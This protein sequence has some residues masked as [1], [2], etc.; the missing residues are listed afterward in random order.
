MINRHK[1]SDFLIIDREGNIIYAD[2]GNPHYFEAGLA[3]LKGKSLKKFYPEIDDSYP[4][5]AAAREGRSCD[6]FQVRLT[7]SRGTSIEKTGC[8][9]PI[10]RKG[11]PVGAV[12][13]S[14]FFYDREHISEITGHAGHIIYRKN[15]TKYILEDIITGDDRMKEIKRRIEKYGISDS[16]VLIYGETGTGKELVAQSLHNCSR[17]YSRQFYSLNCSAIPQNLV[18]SL[19]FGTTKGS[20]TGAEDTKGLF[21]QADGGTLFLDEIN[22]LDIYSQVKIFRAVEKKVIRR[23]GSDQEI[24]VDVRIIAATNEE[25]HKLME[26]GRLKPDLYYRLAGIYLTLPRLADRRGDILLLSDYFV[27]Y[28]NEKMNYHVEYLSEEIKDLFMGYSWPGNVRELRNI[29]EGAF[30]F[31]E[32]G[33]IT[34]EDLPEYLKEEKDSRK[35]RRGS[36][37]EKK[38]ELEKSLIAAVYQQCGGSL[39]EAAEK[40]GISKQLLKYKMDK[41]EMER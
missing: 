25:P 36:L 21:E 28:F 26:E 7:T 38:E 2:V 33:R 4:S 22:S 39:T 24:K 19:L 8:A 12:E 29:I 18:E 13:F 3:N 20:F 40:L 14:D 27:D 32:N 5:I 30:A 23:I 15:N 35:S 37:T 17:R 6:F 10:F 1:F 9:Y 31:V 11:E 16:S 34:L 41:Y